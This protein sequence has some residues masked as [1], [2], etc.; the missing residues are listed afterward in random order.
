MQTVVR[1]V[2]IKNNAY[3]VYNSYSTSSKYTSKS[4]VD[5]DTFKSQKQTDD[6]KWF[7]IADLNG[8]VQSSVVS[9]TDSKSESLSSK[10][11]NKSKDK[12]N[13]N[14]NQNTTS[15]NDSMKTINSG[16]SQQ[17]T[18]TQSTVN[19]KNHGG[20]GMNLDTGE[21]FNSVGEPLAGFDQI[22]N[23]SLTYEP[24]LDT[25][26]IGADVESYLD[27]KQI[28][29]VFGMPYQYAP[30]VDRR[31]VSGSDEMEYGRKF[32]EKIVMN[33][34]LLFMTPGRPQFMA[35]YSDSY[36]KRIM[37]KLYEMGINEG[38]DELTDVGNGRYYSFKFAYDE[39]Y[40]Y[41]NLMV[42]RAACILGI[43]DE[44]FDGTP[45]K[46]YNW[47]NYKNDNL[48]TFISGSEYTT[49][50][51][52]AEP[53]T[54]ESFGNSTGD[55][56]IAS[57]I[58]QLSDLGKEV[59]FLLGAGA[60]YDLE[61]SIKSGMNDNLQS[62]TNFFNKWGGN[63]AGAIANKIFGGVSTLAMGG[64][65]AFPEI[66]KDSDYTQSYN[67]TVKLITPDG[68]P[69]SQFINVMVPYYHLLGFVLPQA[70]G[71][72]EYTSPFLVRASYGGG[73]NCEMGIITSMDVQKGPSW[74]Q[75]KMPLEM[76]ISFTIKDLYKVMAMTNTSS[77][78]EFLKHSQFVDF[79]ANSVGVNI[80]MPEIG[81]TLS[82]YKDF[83]LG[84]K[85][86]TSINN[87][88][89]SMTNFLSNQVSKLKILW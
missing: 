35:G 37:Q 31:L 67:V 86:N 32:T 24:D 53:T 43:G 54:N 77:T 8:W 69:Y 1:N 28:K 76:T 44:K 42:Q 41:V 5:G 87:I 66:W 71:Y 55:S 59:S 49:F 48:K 45:L 64:H 39:Y 51:I 3:D 85:V 89:N 46:R 47:A 9:L 61:A 11:Q 88:Q 83:M 57:S 70:L 52:E 60:G 10:D 80:N 33:A 19:E 30:S 63:G 81:R 50:Y 73:F 20:G 29:G 21:K 4:I 18:N 17:E 34:P 75:F 38:G 62:F 74:N 25:Y 15:T 78:T 6:G 56:S 82:M 84:G 14:Q 68:D 58:N 40:S 36:K 13:G 2:K 26:D 27:F 16:N 12:Y 23:E 22:S 72:N 7:Y 65:L 79:L